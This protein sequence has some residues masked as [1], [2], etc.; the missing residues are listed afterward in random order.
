MKVINK[1]NE[2]TPTAK[3][4]ITSFDVKNIPEE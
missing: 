2:I 1:F 3:I 4:V